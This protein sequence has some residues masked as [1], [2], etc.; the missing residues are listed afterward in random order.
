MVAMVLTV[1]VA[2]AAFAVDF[3]WLYWNGIKI[4]H[5]A[6]A[7]A[8]SGVVYEPNDRTTAYAEARDAARENGYNDLDAGTSVTPVD[9]AQDPTAVR[10]SSQLAVTV[11]DDVPTFFMQ[12]FGVDTV[13]IS[14]HA[15]AEYVLPL[16]MG[17]DL[18]Y[19]GNDPALG[20]TPNFWANIHGYY[21]GRRMGDRYASQ[22]AGG[23]ARYGC[24]ENPEVRY[25]TNPGTDDATGGYVY[26]IEVPPGANGLSVDV[27]DGPFYRDGNDHFLVGDNPQGSNEAEQ[28]GGPTTH[29]H[30]YA[31]DPTPLD[32]TDGNVLL[33][34]VSFGPEDN[35]A[36]FDGDDNVGSWDSDALRWRADPDDDRN[37]DGW[38]DWDDVI[39]EP[40]V[41]INSLWTKMCGTSFNNG[42]GIY[43][44]RVLI[45]DPGDTPGADYRG[46]NRY[47]LRAWTSSGSTPRIYGLGDMSLYV[48]ASGNTATFDF[49]EVEEVHRGKTLV[50]E[51]WDSDSGITNVAIKQPGGGTQECEWSA[52]NPGNPGGTD[53]DCSIPTGSLNMNDHQMEIRLPIDTGYTCASGGTDCWW[54]IDLIY[55]NG[56][57]DTTTWAAHI[58][59]NPVKLVE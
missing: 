15:I 43:P 58:E 49:A 9:F 46:L 21:T 12:V 59:G 13:S 45:E 42:P 37:G 23:A 20:R 28:D 56:A 25:S 52:T 1:L 17:S 16:A 31:P 34:S 53:S 33:C 11:T 32:T 6:D 4:Q 35:F 36:D 3:G 8:L 26:G 19:F 55:N 50:I 29:F 57:N 41:D 14:K 10:N 48:N 5:G 7:A 40:S 47:S 38:F 18:P 27:F 2:M 24:D 54:T 44:L 39:L 22:C 51:L 30:L